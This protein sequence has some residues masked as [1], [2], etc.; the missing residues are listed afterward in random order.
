MNYYFVTCLEKNGSTTIIYPSGKDSGFSDFGKTMLYG[1]WKTKKEAIETIDKHTEEI[2]ED[3]YP[4][5]LI[6]EM[7]PG[8]HPLCFEDKRSWLKYNAGKYEEVDEVKGLHTCNWAL[9]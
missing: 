3:G 2:M 4:Y 9:G 5:I 1:F 8:I 6:E 7:E